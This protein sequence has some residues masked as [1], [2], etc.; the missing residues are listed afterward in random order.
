[1]AKEKFIK[2]L[3]LPSKFNKMI[4][5]I[6]GKKHS[7]VIITLC[8]EIYNNATSHSPSVAENALDALYKFITNYNENAQNG[9]FEKLDLTAFFN[10]MLN[11]YAAHGQTTPLQQLLNGPNGQSF[12]S[13]PDAIIPALITATKAKQVPWKIAHTGTLTPPS[14]I[15]TRV[16]VHEI[17]L[18]GTCTRI[19][20][21]FFI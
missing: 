18:H 12:V 21:A 5:H 10:G 15:R 13:L 9:A 19:Q 11:R 17:W 3:G 1:M 14:G 7:K 8:N 6:D 16:S 4:E 2:G 20:I